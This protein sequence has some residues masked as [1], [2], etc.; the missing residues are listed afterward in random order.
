MDKKNSTR[1]VIGFIGLLVLVS[2]WLTWVM[3]GNYNKDSSKERSIL[4]RAHKEATKETFTYD[5]KR[6]SEVYNKFCLRCHGSNGAGTMS[7]PPLAGSKLVNSAPE[8][9]TKL[10]VNGMKGKIERAGRVYDMVMPGFKMITNED[11]A[12][13]LSYVRSSFGNE[14]SEVNK[15]KVIEVKVENVERKRPWTEAEL[16][17]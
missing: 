15:V 3:I 8:V 6:G 2:A 1:F 9:I 12:H 10:V 4:T 16:L 5:A 7:A 17:K 11:L 13:V 14:S